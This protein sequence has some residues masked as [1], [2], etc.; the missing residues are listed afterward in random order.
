M[1][2]YLLNFWHRCPNGHGGVENWRLGH[3][4]IDATRKG[5]L[6]QAR[7]WIG[8]TMDGRAVSYVEVSS[9]KTGRFAGKFNR[10]FARVGEEG[11]EAA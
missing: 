10:P 11:Q 2:R 9:Q 4:E 8:Q 3:A 1:A 6:A 7:D 5:A